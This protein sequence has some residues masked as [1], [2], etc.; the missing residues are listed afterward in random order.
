MVKKTILMEAVIFSGTKEGAQDFLMT[1]VHVTYLE[2]KL[3]EK[4]LQSFIG[5]L[6]SIFSVHHSPKPHRPM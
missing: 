6:W 2:A 3:F 4:S 5:C 1:L